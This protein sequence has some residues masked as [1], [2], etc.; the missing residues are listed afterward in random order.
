MAVF[1]REGNAIT[2][3][4]AA[5]ARVV[6]TISTEESG[7]VYGAVDPRDGRMF[8]VHERS[9]YLSIVNLREVRVEGRAYI[10]SG[11]TSVAVDPRTGRIY[12]G[13]RGVGAVEIFDPSSLLPIDR[14]SGDGDA[15][16]L[17]VDAQG[18]RLYVALAGRDQVRSYRLP[19]GERSERT[20]VP[21]PAAWIAVA[22]QD[23]SR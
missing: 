15:V 2:M 16:H 14:L 20:D 10:G 4:D 12:V 13:R 5:A 19:G 18:D 8:V 21:G 3:I 6:A 7:P 1:S 9:P 23:S 11:G 22:G 17:V